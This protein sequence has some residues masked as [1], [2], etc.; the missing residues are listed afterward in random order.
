MSQ[1]D[2]VICLTDSLP[3]FNQKVQL[4]FNE[5]Y[6]RFSFVGT[7]ISN[8]FEISTFAVSVGSRHPFLSSTEDD[9]YEKRLVSKGPP[10]SLIDSRLNLNKSLCI[11]IYMYIYI[12]VIIFVE[13]RKVE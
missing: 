7:M 3:N 1:V 10:Q 6:G 9:N 13:V 4:I 5:G 11:Y 8:G 12:Y 2:N